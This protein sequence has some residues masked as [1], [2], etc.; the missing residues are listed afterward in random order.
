ME[1]RH[2]PNTFNPLFTLPKTP[3][4]LLQE[5]LS[6]LLINSPPKPSYEPSALAGLF[7]GPTGLAYLF[8]H[9]SSLHP[10][11]TILEKPAIHWAKEYIAGDRGV[12]ILKP[13]CCGLISEKLCLEAVRACITK[14]LSHVKE[15][16][17]NIPALL[18]PPSKGNP[19]NDPFPSELPYGRAGALYLLRM[20]RHWVP[21]SAPLVERSIVLITERILA[22]DDNGAGDWIYRNRRYIGAGHGDM[23]I[24]A[25]LILTTPPLAPQLE[26]R[27]ERLLD[28][29]QPNGNWS[30]FED[31][32]EGDEMAPELVQWCHGVPGFVISL[33]S[34]RPFFPRL[35]EK[36]DAAVERGRECTWE[37]GLLRKEPNLCHG[38]LGNAL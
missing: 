25:Q 5:A 17:K 28:M 12:L 16:V 18:T 35:Q 30:K 31:E 23:G 1:Q 11:L 3:S 36:I 37:L 13:G 27:I 14:D 4:S 19:Q 24:L 10:T 20:I 29:Q 6:E 33:L 9:I 22:T 2:I 38:I 34:L 26:G 15:F 21:N 8:L 7:L 32:A